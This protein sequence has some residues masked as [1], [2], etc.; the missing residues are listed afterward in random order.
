V[1]LPEIEQLQEEKAAALAAY[2]VAHPGINPLEDRALE[3]T[4]R[5]E[6]DVRKSLF[7]A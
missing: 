1:F 2:R 3:V 4:S 7:R 5:L 6:I